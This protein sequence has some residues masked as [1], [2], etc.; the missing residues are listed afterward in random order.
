MRTWKSN[1]APWPE[2]GCSIKEI[3]GV[4]SVE[5][6][7]RAETP[8]VCKSVY[9]TPPRYLAWSVSEYLV[10]KICSNKIT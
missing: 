8:S 5:G 6:Y 9:W 2:N 10:C 3:F 7:L 4:K 1:G